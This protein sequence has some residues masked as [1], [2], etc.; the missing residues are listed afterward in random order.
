VDQQL[1]H[2]QKEGSKTCASIRSS[3]EGGARTHFL[4]EAQNVARA[5]ARRVWK[6]LSVGT[7]DAWSQRAQLGVHAIWGVISTKEV[8]RETATIVREFGPAVYVRCCLAILRGR[9]TTFLN[10]VFAA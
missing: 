10:C 7:R 1:F 4:R 6:A 2:C 5:P 8:L 3:P 9:R